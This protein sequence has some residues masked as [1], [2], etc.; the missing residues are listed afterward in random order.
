MSNQTQGPKKVSP[1]T[2]PGGGCRASGS[3]FGSDFSCSTGLAD[4]S[5]GSTCGS[6]DYEDSLPLPPHPAA[7]VSHGPYHQ[8]ERSPVSP[9]RTFLDAPTAGRDSPGHDSA[10]SSTTTSSG[11]RN[12]TASLD[13]G[14]MTGEQ[15]R[16]SGAHHPQYQH[17]MSTVQSYGGGSSGSSV[18]QSY[19]SSHSSSSSLSSIERAEDGISV[20]NIQ[21]MINQCVPDHQILAS[22]LTDIRMEEYYELFVSAGYDMP[23]VSRMTP[24]D[25]TAIGIKKPNHRKKIKLEIDKLE[26]TDGLPDYIPNSIEE[27]LTLLRLDEYAGCLRSQGYNTVRDITT[28]TV[29]DLEDAGFFQLG[30]QKRLML[31]IKQVKDI[32]AGRR[33]SRPRI[34]PE[35]SLPP[36][37]YQPQEMRVAGFPSM[38]ERSRSGSFSSFQQPPGPSIQ[39]QRIP[40]CQFSNPH[41]LLRIQSSPTFPRHEM[42]PEMS[43]M[44]QPM[45]PIK[46]PSF[47][48]KSDGGYGYLGLGSPQP[49][50]GHSSAGFTSMPS[51]PWRRQRSYD[52]A[53]ILRYADHSVVIHE[54]PRRDPPGGGTLPRL[55]KPRPV[56][57]IIAHARETEPCE[58]ELKICEPLSDIDEI[59][60]KVNEEIPL[61]M[62]QSSVDISCDNIEEQLDQIKN[63]NRNSELEIPSRDLVSDDGGSPLPFASDNGGTIRL[64]T[65]PSSAELE[66]LSKEEK[67]KIKLDESGSSQGRERSK[68]SAGDV[69]TDIGSMLADLTDELDTML[70][71]DWT[72][73]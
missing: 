62:V 34:T 53:D 67:E 25:L 72:N 7:P 45:A 24:E 13:S 8:Q 21:D 1:P 18:R 60:R 38:T 35:R 3:S 48:N 10:V 63:L 15:H 70:Q 20:M 9:F 40:Q 46:Y 32:T 22:W 29:E 59:K 50:R 57:K 71:M 6:T 5:Y 73:K 37:K 44:P 4:L 68:R 30:H 49:P 27:W 39:H 54:P 17:R 33:V 11:Y 43:G 66:E 51:A 52:D 14:R 61:K 41:P 56:A 47:L 64:K 42:A 16:C 26:I 36:T 69:L 2:V 28:I 58:N 12:S 23:T 19:H 31:G 65:A 55:N